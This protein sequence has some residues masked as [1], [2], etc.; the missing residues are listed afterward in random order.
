M[1]EKIPSEASIKTGLLVFKVT[2]SRGIPSSLYICRIKFSQ[3]LAPQAPMP[4]LVIALISFRSLTPFLLKALSH[5][6][7]LFRNG[8]LL[9]HPV[10]W[11]LK[12][13]LYA[14]HPSFLYLKSR[15]FFG[16]VFGTLT[17]M[18]C[19]FRDDFF[20]IVSTISAS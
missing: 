3:V 17:L 18:I 8:T 14:V 12:A 9:R 4:A 7:L 10:F 2:S 5:L 13:A 19:V 11:E 16:N 20:K 1:L 15:D 6:Q